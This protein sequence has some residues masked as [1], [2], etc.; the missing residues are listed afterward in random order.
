[1]NHKNSAMCNKFPSSQR[2]AAKSARPLK[3]AQE[4]T[5]RR[6]PGKHFTTW[7]KSRQ[8]NNIKTKLSDV[9]SISGTRATKIPITVQYNNV[10]DLKQMF[11]N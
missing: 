7:R 3:Y 9:G 5:A 6:S 4:K 11:Q 2:T 8:Y 10:T 1:M